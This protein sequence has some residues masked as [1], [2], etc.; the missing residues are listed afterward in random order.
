MNS[1][2]YSRFILASLDSDTAA[3]NSGSDSHTVSHR[4][5]PLGDRFHDCSACRGKALNPQNDTQPANGFSAV[6]AI[7][8]LGH[9]S[10][11]RPA[12]V[13]EIF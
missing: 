1:A 12:R 13:K 3:I 4:C 8:F 5:S 2:D 11:S 9:R 10:V 7:G 6:S